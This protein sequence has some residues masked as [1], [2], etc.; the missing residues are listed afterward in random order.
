MTYQ[1]ATVYYYTGTGNS[2]RVA[3]WMVDALAAAGTTVTLR[4]IG[5][6]HPTEEI[7]DGAVALL[8]L[9]MPTHGFTTPW[10]MLCFAFGLPRR[11]GTHAVVVATRAGMRIGSF[12]TPGFEGTAT[13][14]V[15]LI[16]AVKGYRIRGTAGIDMPSNWIALH[17][18]LS[19]Q[20][21]SGIVNRAEA[22][23]A[24]FMSTLVSG[25]HGFPNWLAPL[26][27]LL[28]L[29]ISVVYLFIGRLFLAKL[30]FASDRCTGCGLCAK[31]CPNGAVVMRGTGKDAR[32]YWTFRCES[33]MRCIGYC[34]PQ[35]V[36]ASHLLAVSVYL[37]AGAIPTA[38]ALV[39]LTVRVPFLAFLTFV[40]RWI[41]ESVNALVALALIYPL[42]HLLL[43]IR[44]VNWFFTHATLTHYYRR[45]REPETRLK[46]LEIP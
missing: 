11:R 2:Y 31:H 34:P 25:R 21:V 22:S 8:G 17:P 1:E 10:A 23:T 29:P 3:V 36:E 27:G 14:L 18:A 33:C 12:Y 38:A 39:W 28:V 41:L 35:A 45:Y 42:F 43:R 16:L 5:S 37:L 30:F 6:T 20:A 40:P 26:L 15:A 46:D 9:V 44:G 7:G 19:P 24:H 4:P 32:P 13:L